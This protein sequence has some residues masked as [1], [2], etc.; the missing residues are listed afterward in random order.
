[1]WRCQCE[2]GNTVI[3][4]AENLHSGNTRSCG[5]I[6]KERPNPT[7]H[8][9]SKTRLAKIYTAMKKRCYNP[10][11]PEFY[12]YGGRGIKICDEW[13]N[14]KTSFFRWSYENGYIENATQAENSIDRIDPNGDY[15]PENCRWVDSF[16]QANNTRR[17]V[18]YE[19]NG[20]SHTLTE[21]GRIVGINS[22]TLYGRVN[23]LGWTIEEALTLRPSHVSQRIN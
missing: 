14:D 19:L 15:S 10:K 9:L 18:Y 7:T 8:G 23:K 22:G 5:C 13:L 20:E 16:V 12:L 21:W 17:N 2:C 1:M 6:E 3:V 11:Y 4:R